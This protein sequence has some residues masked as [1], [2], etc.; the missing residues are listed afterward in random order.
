MVKLEKH[1]FFVIS[2]MLIIILFAFVYY[3][4]FIYDSKTFNIHKNDEDI[5]Y[6]DFLYF[7]LVTQT[8]VG[9]GGIIP[10]RN[11]SRLLNFIQL[12]TIYGIVAITIFI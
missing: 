7:S 10:T 2:H 12:L 6:L 11:I 9:Y 3:L 4:T 8:T 5:N 1:S